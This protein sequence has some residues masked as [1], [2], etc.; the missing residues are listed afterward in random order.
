[1]AQLSEVFSEESGIKNNQESL[2]QLCLG[3][4]FLTRLPDTGVSFNFIKQL[5]Q[6]QLLAVSV[7]AFQTPGEAEPSSGL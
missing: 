3:G 5:I 7:G 6:A 2:H 4:F 1:M